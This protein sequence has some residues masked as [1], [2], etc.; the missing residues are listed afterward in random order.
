MAPSP[1]STS[2]VLAAMLG[3]MPVAH[4]VA[5]IHGLAL[6]HP[7]R[8]AKARALLVETLLTDDLVTVARVAPLMRFGEL[9]RAC[10]ACGLSAKANRV[11]VLEGRLAAAEAGLP[12][13]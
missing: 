1:R 5:T 6:A 3:A 9:Q 13:P 2:P 12:R 10:T 8:H 11:Q 4:L 7:R